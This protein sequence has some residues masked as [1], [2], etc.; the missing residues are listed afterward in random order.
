MSKL[1]REA[2]LDRA[3]ALA[4]E[5]GVAAVSVRRLAALLD[6]TPMALYWHFKS[7][8]ELF[9][10]AADHLLADVTRADPATGA[11]PS[12]DARLRTMVGTLIDL[13]R[14]HPCLAELLRRADKNHVINFTLATDTVLGLLRAEGFTLTEGYHI[15]S[16]LLNGCIGLIAGDPMCDVSMTAE[17]AAEQRRLHRLAVQ[18]LPADRFP[19]VVEHARTA[20]EPPDTEAYYALGLDLLVGGVRSLVASRR[21]ERRAVMTPDG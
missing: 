13:M 3:V 15:A 10:A 4:D 6:V 9:T 1:S 11:D 7:K 14:A 17:E 21:A 8:E 18:K 12:W 5:E 2:V 19:N 20:K 16:Y